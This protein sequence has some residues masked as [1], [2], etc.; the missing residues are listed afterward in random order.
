MTAVNPS[1]P[2]EREWFRPDIHPFKKRLMI[3]KILIQ[4]RT[5]L[6][7]SIQ[8][9]DTQFVTLL[10]ACRQVVMAHNTVDL[11][12]R[13]R[14]V[15]KVIL[16]MKR[17]IPEMGQLHLDLP[18]Y[19]K[20]MTLEVLNNNFN[21]R[22]GGS[23]LIFTQLFTILPVQSIF[24]STY[25]KLKKFHLFFKTYSLL[26]FKVCNVL[27]ILKKYWEACNKIAWIT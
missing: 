20:V 12:F 11:Y 9:G 6:I 23:T 13:S 26:L 17:Y 15:K 22:L 3:S 1:P 8:F 18:L 19:L 25:L 27:R 7:Y 16:S 2:S 10:I 5:T 24:L 14:T 21:Y 4:N